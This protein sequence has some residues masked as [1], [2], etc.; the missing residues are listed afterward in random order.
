MQLYELAFEDCND[1]QYIIDMDT[2]QFLGVNRAFINLTGYTK[3]ELLR[4]I[5]Y[6]DL[7]LKEDIPQLK[8]IIQRRRSG[9]ISERY[10]FRI[11]TKSQV[12]IPVE[13]SARLVK[14][15]TRN[16]VIG[17]WRDTSERQL[18]EK[19][20]REKLSELAQANNRILL[21]T[22]KIKETPRITSSLLRIPDEMHLIKNV[23]LALADRRQF[24]YEASIIYLLD[25]R[26]LRYCYGKGMWKSS[27]QKKM[28][29]C[30]AAFRCLGMGL[31]DK[32]DVR[33]NHIIANAFR[34][35]VSNSDKDILWD[36]QKGC[37]ILPLSGRERILGVIILKINPREQEIMEAN[38]TAK[39]GYYDVLKTL[40]NSVGLAIENLRLTEALKIQSI[41]DGLTGVY[42]RRYFE[43]TFNEE[44]QRASRYR[45]K[46]ALL[47]ID[48]DNFKSINDTYGHKQGDSILKEVSGILQRH[49]RKVD[50]VCRYGGDEFAII[51]PETSLEGAGSKAK[52]IISRVEDYPFTNL[53]NPKSPFKIR[54]SIGTSSISD[55]FKTPDE[56]VIA[57]DKSLFKKKG[58]RYALRR[59]GLSSP[60]RG[61]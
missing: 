12:I 43:N 10:S 30:S 13:V 19:T 45:R 9:V 29:R 6:P 2:L 11:K 55:S 60:L 47:F 52:N 25:N 22:E 39:K 24:N 3:E 61:R 17:S 56:M 36:E 42:N 37:V 51:L 50:S 23:C 58:S 28:P 18:W 7:I 33:K 41:H 32:I 38:P 46:L 21:L 16:L 35:F 34:T 1:P 4:D 5:K 31:P 59:T 49:S 26:Y 53:T 44:F 40:V 48:L 57:A 27:P 20:I 54:V 14:V 8:R 15:D